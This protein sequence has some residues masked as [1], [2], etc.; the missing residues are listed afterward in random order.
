MK[1]VSIR[2]ATKSGWVSKAC[3]KETLVS[4]PAMRNSPSARAA[5]AAAAAK[6]PDGEWTISLA[7]RESKAAA[8][9]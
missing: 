4:T 6:P 3:R 1:R 2:P 8:V 9:R 7:M 5:F